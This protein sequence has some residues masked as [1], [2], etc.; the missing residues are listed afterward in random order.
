MDWVEDLLVAEG[1]RFLAEVPFAAH[2][3]DASPLDKT[4]YLRHRIETVWRIW[5]TARTDAIALTHMLEEDYDAARLWA[6][7]TVEELNHDRLFLRDLAEHGIGVDEVRRV[8]PFKATRSMVDYIEAQMRELGSL[9]AVAYSLFVEW[10]SEQ[11]SPA[12]V[13]KA[14][15]AFSEC[16]VAGS[17]GH[18]GIDVAES[19]LPMIFDIARSLV[20]RRHSRQVL[21]FL[22]KDIAACFREYFIELYAATCNSSIA[23]S[24][25]QPRQ[26]A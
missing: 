7:Y 19:H 5:L 21:E 8:G 24:S 26:L 23:T 2:L 12:A 1:H 10:N 25:N 4:Y 16:H 15:A 18:V 22:L 3:T 11:F 20:D 14:E 6:E 17:K 13:A 9:P